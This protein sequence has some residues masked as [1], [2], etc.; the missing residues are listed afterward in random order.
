M[1]VSQNFFKCDV[2]KMG[3]I[4]KRQTCIERSLTG[5]GVSQNRGNIH[6]DKKCQFMP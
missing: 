3:V 2:L 6:N 4:M 5:D 1:F